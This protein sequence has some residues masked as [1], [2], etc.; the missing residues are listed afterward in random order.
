MKER[1]KLLLLDDDS[2]LGFNLKLYFED[3]AIDCELFENSEGALESLK[4]NKYHCAI[5]DIRLP[6]MDGEEFIKNAL[7]VDANLKFIIHTGSTH[8]TLSK[9]LM[10][11][12]L[13]R[14]NVCGKPIKDMKLFLAKIKELTNDNRPS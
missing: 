13:S 4:S 12:G 10:D 1:I 8:F 2:N 6:G 9:E 5:V 11:L 3:E 14:E 7:Q